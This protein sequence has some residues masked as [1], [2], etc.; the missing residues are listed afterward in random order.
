MALLIFFLLPAYLVVFQNLLWYIY[1]WQIKEYRV[2]RVYSHFRFEDKFDRS[3]LSFLLIKL[4]LVF[5]SMLYLFFPR[6]LAL[7]VTPLL[8]FVLYLAM[9]ERMAR[10][11]I[12]RRLQR[13]AIKS[14]RNI[15]ILLWSVAV[16]LLPAALLFGWLRSLPVPVEPVGSLVELEQQTSINILPLPLILIVLATIVAVTTDLLTHL[17][18]FLGVLL[19]NPMASIKRRG[20]IRKAK[21]K[22]GRS[23]KLKIVAV[24]G[25]YGKTTTKELIY[26]LVKDTYTTVKTPENKNTDVG[27][28]QT[29]LE[30]INEN[31]E[32]LIAEMGAYHIGEIADSTRLAP[33]DIAVVTGVDQQH[34]SLFGTIENTFKAKFEIVQGLKPEGIA[35]LNGNNEYTLNMAAKTDKKK[36]L[37][38]AVDNTNFTVTEVDEEK[39]RVKSK[40]KFPA[41]S[42]L[43]ATTIVQTNEGIAFDLKYKGEKH[44]V[45]TK[46]KASHNISNLLAAVSVAVELGVP[47]EK[48]VGRIQEGEL[49]DK[50][51]AVDEGLGGATIIDDGYNSNPTGFL[52]ALKFLKGF[53][54][55]G[56]RWIMT[57]GV[58]ELGQ[59][60]DSL[61]GRFAEQIASSSDGLITSDK[62]LAEAVNEKSPKFPVYLVKSGPGFVDTYTRRVNKGD[63]VLIEGRFEPVTMEA[64]TKSEDD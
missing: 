4:A 23:K 47:V 26:E 44:H 37:Y 14:A 40:S 34:I 10:N 30:S 55:K 22:L 51:L 24:T 45:K 27:I 20:L 43:Y 12:G 11:L 13:P 33:P 18:V 15:L 58:I 8:A 39:Q 3:S 25:S 42:N 5:T 17:V 60:Q 49:S 53:E 52:E 31:T 41:D 62:V 54:T 19:T 59:E 35:I 32:V 29:I 56:K 64:I 50:Y 16:L 9:L 2:D 6:S 28:A 7:L 61:Y 57:Q 38:F 46:F 63:T 21:Q 1:L 48:V 36:L